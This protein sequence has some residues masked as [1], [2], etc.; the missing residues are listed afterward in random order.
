M[1][2]VELY[3]ILEKSQGARGY[4]FNRDEQYTLAILDGL[5][6]NRE[7]YG[8]MACPCRL[9]AGERSRDEDIICPCVYREDD[10]QEYGSCY[11]KLYVDRTRD[12][13]LVKRTEVPERRPPEMTD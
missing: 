11:C 3:A 7:R 2:A 5:L 13:E 8:Y 1:D 4:H 10:L 12:P 6:A 9:V